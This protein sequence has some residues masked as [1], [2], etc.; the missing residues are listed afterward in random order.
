MKSAIK[1]LHIR[2]IY[3]TS[4]TTLLNLKQQKRKI[5][6]CQERTACQNSIE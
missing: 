6:F 5:G 1:Y 4:K 3:N 2:P